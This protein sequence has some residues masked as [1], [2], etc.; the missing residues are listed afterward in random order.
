MSNETTK[1]VDGDYRVISNGEDFSVENFIDGSVG[2]YRL[3]GIYKTK[4]EAIKQAQGMIEIRRKLA[5]P[6]VQV[7]P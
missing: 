6:W 3:P 7:W 5:L 1:P 2:W 4:E